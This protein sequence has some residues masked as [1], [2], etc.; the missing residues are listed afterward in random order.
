MKTPLTQSQKHCLE[1][2]AHFTTPDAW[3][4]NFKAIAKQTNMDVKEIRRCVR[5]LARKGL[6][7]FHKGLF[8]EDGHLAGAGYCITRQGLSLAKELWPNC[9]SQDPT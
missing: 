6:A 1:T 2:L 9:F 4:T 5:A 8:T 7:E 3:C